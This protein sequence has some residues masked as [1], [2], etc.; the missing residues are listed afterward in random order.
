MSKAEREQK[1]RLKRRARARARRY[2]KVSNG[3]EL[4]LI[5]LCFLTF[6]AAAVMEMIKERA[7]IQ[8]V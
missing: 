1:R 3:L 6:L 4:C 2:K 5:A 7:G 8:Q